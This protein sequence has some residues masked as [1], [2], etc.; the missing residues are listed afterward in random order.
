MFKHLK[1][2]VS[3]D[4]LIV[5]VFPALVK[6]VL[7]YYHYVSADGVSHLPCSD[8]YCGPS[9]GSEPE[10]Q[11]VQR[12]LMRISSTVLASVTIHSYGN[13]W[14]FPWGNTVNFGGQ[15]CQL[16]DDHDELVWL[17]YTVLVI[18]AYLCLLL[19]MF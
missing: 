16:A 2:A 10:T 13:M 1:S 19:F 5:Y 15:T 11:S 8:L 9:G 14:M 4:F 12:E 6:Q 17:S 3:S 7:P 18:N